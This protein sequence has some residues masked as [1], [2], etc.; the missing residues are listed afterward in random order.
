MLV[1]AVH[2]SIRNQSKK[3]K[4]MAASFRENILGDGIV[5]QL[6]FGNGFVDPGEILINNPARAEV[7][8][9]DFGVAHL[10]LRQTDVRTTGT[11]FPSGIIAVKPV[12]ERGA[13][14]QGGVAVLLAFFAAAGIDSPT[15]ANDENNRPGHGRN[16]ALSVTRTSAFT[17]LRD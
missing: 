16:L 10:S 9:A 7:E 3:M 17:G 2:T 1:M 5:L 4:A 13:G 14:K 15:I 11:Q 8:V 6:S 12:V